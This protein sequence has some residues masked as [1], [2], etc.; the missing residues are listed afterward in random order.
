[1]KGTCKIF[2]F[3]RPVACHGIPIFSVKG[4]KEFNHKII[5]SEDYY[6]DICT[7]PGTHILK[8]LWSGSRWS[9]ENSPS[10]NPQNR[11]GTVRQKGKVDQ[12]RC[13][14]VSA[15]GAATHPVKKV[16]RC[17]VL[18]LLHTTLTSHCSYFTL[19]LLHTTLT[20][21]YSYFTLLLLHTTLTR[22]KILFVYRKFL[23]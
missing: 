1:M 10:R 13:S 8:H 20:S 21:H 2:I 7:H 15:T 19:L 18:L 14:S 3:W 23:I 22:E 4:S 6:E 16:A 11:L 9:L 5:S 12:D 17:V